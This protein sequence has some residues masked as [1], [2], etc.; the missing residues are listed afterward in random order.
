MNYISVDSVAII[1][2]VG[3]KY[4]HPACSKTHNDNQVPISFF[5]SS[6]TW[7]GLALPCVAFMT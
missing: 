7:A 5:S 3:N 1:S 6:L 2:T 4:A